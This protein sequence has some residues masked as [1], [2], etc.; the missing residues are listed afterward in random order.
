MFS[1]TSKGY[2]FDWDCLLVLVAFGICSF[3]VGVILELLKRRVKRY[4]KI[5]SIF[6]TIFILI[7]VAFI[8]LTFVADYQ[9]SNTDWE[10][11]SIKTE[12]L[13]SAKDNNLIVGN[14]GFRRVRISEELYYQYY[15]IG[16][17]NG[18]Y[19]KQIRASL[20]DV[21][22]DDTP[23]VETYNIKRNWLVWF[24]RDVRYKLYVPQNSL[25]QEFE[26]DLN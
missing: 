22:F 5:V 8:P 17:N 24:Q 14:G 9:L 26:L 6:S 11:E 20:T 23:R 16:S 25:T 18:Y 13:L 7:P 21:F 1:V 3:A 19:S 12:Y 4:Q 15:A 10:T 2:V